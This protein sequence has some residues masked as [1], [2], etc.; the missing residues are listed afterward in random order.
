MS[1]LQHVKT[2]LQYLLGAAFAVVATAAFNVVAPDPEQQLALATILFAALAAILGLL[3]FSSI[4]WPDFLKRYRAFLL[5]RQTSR[6][7]VP[8]A[9]TAS[10][11]VLAGCV[12]LALFANQLETAY[13][14]YLA[15][16]VTDILDGMVA[17]SIDGATDWGKRFDAQVDVLFNGATGI[18]LFWAGVQRGSLF[19]T[20]TVALLFS[21]FVL[22]LFWAPTGLLPKYFSGL[23]R[24]AFFVLFMV[25]LPTAARGQAFVA[26]TGIL[27][28]GAWY[29]QRVMLA[30][31]L[32]S[33]DGASEIPVKK[34]QRDA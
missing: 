16:L 11:A 8:N 29:E 20:V 3:Y 25:S 31:A 26:G 15:G 10:R 23:V 30:S 2:V 13:W 24:V 32:R 6:I 34:E 18:A 7:S 21:L 22:R 14:F 12:A 9:L 19:L 1:D 27:L 28:F 5:L 17:R 33:S 4:Y